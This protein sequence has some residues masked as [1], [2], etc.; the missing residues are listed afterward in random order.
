[1]DVRQAADELDRE[2]TPW[3]R[4][5]ADTKEAFAALAPGR[6][7][8]F[9]LRYSCIA[10]PVEVGFDLV[11]SCV[12]CGCLTFTRVNSLVHLGQLL[13]EADRQEEQHHDNRDDREAS[14]P[15][16]DL[17]DLPDRTRLM[18]EVLTRLLVLHNDAGLRAEHAVV[19]GY[20][21]GN[22]SFELHLKA[23][24]AEAAV[25][26]AEAL[27]AD[28][29]VTVVGDTVMYVSRRAMATATVDGITVQLSGYTRLPDDEAAAWLAEQ[30]QAADGGEG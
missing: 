28:P 12:S 10:D 19:I 3:G 23:A 25:K 9:A 6:Y 29:V 27:G 4:A 13:E 16:G 8:S 15:V 21:D 18:T 5:P 30:N 1:G 22:C 26:V 24:S 11:A 2:Y 14:D 20:R 7:H 17:A